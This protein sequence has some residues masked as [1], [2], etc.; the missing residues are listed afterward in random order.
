MRPTVWEPPG[1]QELND[2]L[3][4]SRDATE[5]Q[6]VVSEALQDVANGTVAHAQ[7]G[8]SAFRR[9]ILPKPYPYSII[10]SETASEVRVIAFPHHKRRT[11]Y[12]RNRLPTP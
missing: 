9:C 11:S 7:I 5:F 2:A 12:W 3:A 4:V 10:Y 1:L 8:R 6:R